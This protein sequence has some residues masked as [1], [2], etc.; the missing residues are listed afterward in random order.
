MAVLAVLFYSL[1][2]DTLTWITAVIGG[3]WDFEKIYTKVKKHKRGYYM[4]GGKKKHIKE[5]W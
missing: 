1:G 3:L 2:F 4:I 5:R